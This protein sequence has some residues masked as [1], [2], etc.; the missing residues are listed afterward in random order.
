MVHDTCGGRDLRI[1]FTCDLRLACVLVGR[2]GVDHLF[3]DGDRV[4]SIRVDR[5]VKTVGDDDML[6]AACGEILHDE[7]LEMPLRV[8]LDGCDAEF[9]VLDRLGHIGKFATGCGQSGVP[10]D[11]LILLRH[12]R[13]L[14]TGRNPK[15]RIFCRHFP[16][17]LGGGALLLESRILPFQLFNGGETCLSRINRI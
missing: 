10:F 8:D 3:V 5:A 9:V 17:P 15:V 13:V 1:Q 7:C 11:F 2:Q 14:R 12:I 16:V 4:V 6:E